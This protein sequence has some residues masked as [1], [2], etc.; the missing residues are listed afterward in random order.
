MRSKVSKDAILKYI[1]EDFIQTAEPVGSKNLVSRHHLDSSSA[2]VR[3]LMATLEKEGLIEKPH[4]SA[5]R[6]PSTAGYQYYLEKLAGDGRG[7]KSS[8]SGAA[9][10]F[11]REFA[12]SLK[13]KT[14]SVESTIT[15]ACKILSD[16]T[17]L[18]TV[19]LGSDGASEKLVSVSVTPISERAAT[20]IL[21]TDR[22]HV[23][24]KTF[25]VPKGSSL[26]AIT[27]GMKLLNDRLT[28]TPLKDLQAKVKTMEPILKTQVGK[29]FQ[30]VME[31][32]AEACI[33]F[34][35]KRVKAYGGNKLMELPEFSEDDSFRR[36]VSALMDEGAP[37]PASTPVK[38]QVSRDTAV[39]LDPDN[40]ISVVTKR[41][42][43]PG[44]PGADIAIVGPTR[45]DY[46]R[47]FDALGAL[48]SQV[49]KLFGFDEESGDESPGETIEI[50]DGDPPESRE[51]GA[52]T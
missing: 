13:S 29:D 7:K 47:V 30:I 50:E 40:D 43:I 25:A 10:D 14:Q 16:V 17:S 31:A 23:E 34:T 6:V 5:G 28:G 12:L 35:R 33:S 51:K 39:N 37:P 20:V 3:N 18:A 26:Q 49:M 8:A 52:A 45:M 22:G 15:Q 24:S 9:A 11:N 36:A 44:L 21:V 42:S 46:R 1:V 41:I 19:V 2:T 38:A 4:T 48:T 27:Y 32:F